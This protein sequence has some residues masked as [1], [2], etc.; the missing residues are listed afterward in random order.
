MEMRMLI[1]LIK[2]KNTR[3]GEEN[4]VYCWRG[5][6]PI[7]TGL[8]GFTDS[9]F[10][11]SAHGQLGKKPTGQKPTGQK[12]NWANSPTGQIPTGQKTNWANNQ[13]GSIRPSAF[14]KSGPRYDT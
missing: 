5:T 10:F 1:Y 2:G 7:V 11:L 6:L 13:L 8:H 3:I 4:L 12:T 14:S 9:A